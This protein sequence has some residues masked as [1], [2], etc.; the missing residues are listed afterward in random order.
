MPSEISDELGR[1]LMSYSGAEPN[2]VR[3]AIATLAQDDTQK[4]KHYLALA[5]QDYRDVLRLADIKMEED[6]KKAELRGMTVNERLAVCGVIS[7]WDDAARRRNRA[8]MIAVLRTVEMSD[9]EAV[10]TTDSVLKDP[11]KYGF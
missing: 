5:C 6:R 7:K 9:E 1:L 2:R 8:E 4:M 10:W 3:T 11:V